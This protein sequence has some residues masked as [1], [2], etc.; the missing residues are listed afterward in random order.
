[1]PL[2]G[3]YS[4]F[5][6]P[7]GGYVV[8]PQTYTLVYERASGTPSDPLGVDEGGEFS[9]RLDTTSIANGTVIPFTTSGIANGSD[10]TAGSLSGNFTVVTD[11]SVNGARY[12]N[13]SARISFNVSADTMTEGTETLMVNAMSSSITVNIYD[14]SAGVPYWVGTSGQTIRSIDVDSNGYLLTG[15]SANNSTANNNYRYMEGKIM[16]RYANGA[17]FWA[18]DYDRDSFMNM[19]A[20]CRERTIT[21]TANTTNVYFAASADTL[22]VGARVYREINYVGKLDGS[23]NLLWARQLTHA[24][25]GGMNW[26]NMLSADH[27]GVACS[28]S[29]ATVVKYNTAGTLQW[30][31]RLTVAGAY[32]RGVVC[33]EGYTWCAWDDYTSSL[34][35]SHLIK[36]DSAG[37]PILKMRA[38]VSDTTFNALDC[39]TVDD[40]Q[41]LYTGGRSNYGGGSTSSLISKKNSNGYSVWSRRIPNVSLWSMEYSQHD[42][43]LYMVGAASGTDRI[44]IA[45]FTTDG[46]AVWERIWSGVY[47]YAP[48]LAVTDGFIYVAHLN[49]SVLKL[50]TDG[51]TVGSPSN[52]ESLSSSI[53]TVTISMGTTTVTVSTGAYT[54]ATAASTIGTTEGTGMTITNY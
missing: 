33:R 53:T 35:S 2:L 17:L 12:P 13:G 32:A 6:G 34:Y 18:R 52:L 23:G 47:A 16:K 22:N 14:T 45:K 7:T 10:F 20:V 36:F 46:N 48:S 25:Y 9:I 21:S 42:G 8:I 11:G 49:G 30:Q 54:S 24:S 29:N 38:T 51:G 4:S 15:G 1:M 39:L 19:A 37:T 3:S 26:E 41:L 5:A 31:K 43:H 28:M 27:T 44:Y 40:N 50:P